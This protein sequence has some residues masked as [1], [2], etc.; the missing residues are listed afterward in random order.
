MAVSKSFSFVFKDW[1]V[2]VQSHGLTAEEWAHSNFMLNVSLSALLGV[3][4]VGGTVFTLR[5]ASREFRLSQ[6]KGDFVSNVSHE[7]R[8]PL[9]SIQAFGELLRRGKVRDPERAREYGDYIET[10]SR[11]LGALIAN[12]LDFS[13]IE[14]GERSYDFETLDLGKTVLEVLD[15]FDIRAREQGFELEIEDRAGGPLTV[16]ADREAV[17][18]AV[19]NLLDNACK[20][21]GDSRRVSV[22]LACRQG[23]AEVGV[24]DFGVGISKTEKSRIFE[25]FHRAT[26]GLVDQVRGSG[27]GLS[28]VHH[29]VDAHLGEI[30]VE[31]EPGAGSTFRL[32]LP[33]VVDE[34]VTDGQGGES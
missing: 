8:T 24:R 6:M 5:T 1:G 30:E 18:Q 12:I 13:S 15:T 16:L 11:R 20:F 34:I 33:L 21:S 26:T 17:V 3:V 25:R 23:Y 4:L 9:A 2:A 10:E 28:I 7:L 32:R 14:S 31:S 29:I 19:S 22:W 27:L